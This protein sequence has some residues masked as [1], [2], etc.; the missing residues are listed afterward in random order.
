[1]TL[2]NVDVD[3][4]NSIEDISIYNYSSL[5]YFFSTISGLIIVHLTTDLEFK[6]DTNSLNILEE[7]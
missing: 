4:S 6:T 5:S 3:R 1:M 2:K 7:M